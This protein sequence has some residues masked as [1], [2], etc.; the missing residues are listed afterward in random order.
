[1]ALVLRAMVPLSI[2][3]E[4]AALQFP[5]DFGS[6]PSLGARGVNSYLG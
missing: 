1:M 3:G 4:P 5:D 6:F 2:M